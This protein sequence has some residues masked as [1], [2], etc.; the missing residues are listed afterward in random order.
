MKLVEFIVDRSRVYLEDGYLLIPPC[1]FLG[2]SDSVDVTCI[3]F[4]TGNVQAKIESAFAIKS[5]AE[6]KNADY[7][8]TLLETWTLQADKFDMRHEI[9]KQFGSI[10]DSPYAV[11]TVSI[12]LETTKGHW[13]ANL[14][15]LPKDGTSKT[16]TFGIP[17][18][19]EFQAKGSLINLLPGKRKFI[20]V[21]QALLGIPG[22]LIYSPLDVGD[23]SRQ[24]ISFFR[25]ILTG[26]SRYQTKNTCP[27]TA[28]FV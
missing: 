14:Q 18:F 4:E 22:C 24:H 21:E 3:D 23:P 7:I 26:N 6:M 28:E 16:R 12:V 17:V 27:P 20:Y 2:R 1:A 5:I 25:L 11:D 15:I 9:I 19:E 13:F 8:L 10:G